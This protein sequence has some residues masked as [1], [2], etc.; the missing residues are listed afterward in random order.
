[1]CTIMNEFNKIQEIW[2]SQPDA[3]TSVLA[4][5]IIQKAE[6]HLKNIKRS[7]IGT[8]VILSITVGVLIAY[9]LWISFYGWSLF[10]IGISL[11]IGMLVWRIALE[12]ISIKRFS[13]I[14]P[15]GAFITYSER[16]TTY[17]IWR[18]KVHL[19]LT[20][21]IYLSYIAGFIFLLPAFKANLSTGMFWYCSISGSGFLI[22]FG[23]Y[24]IHLIRKE[25]KTLEY[26]KGIRI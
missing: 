7:Y 1:M 18:K 21:I 11:M 16:I 20:P 23:I 2:N 9:F 26:L 17:H 6:T 10:T 22:G 13:G 14:K 3:K 15:D 19:I 5:D 4:G 8:T 24:L 25:I 12:L